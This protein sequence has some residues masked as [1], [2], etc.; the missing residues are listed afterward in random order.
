MLKK[1]N[2]LRW[3]MLALAS[4][5]QGPTWAEEE[6]ILKNASIAS[7]PSGANF[8][9]SDLSCT[10]KTKKFENACEGIC[11]AELMFCAK[12]NDCNKEDHLETGG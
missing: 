2:Q 4:S 6:S 1:R 8:G 9:I 12:T 11:R 3:A 5:L 7:C 10:P